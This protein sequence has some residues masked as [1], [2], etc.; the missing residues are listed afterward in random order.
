MNATRQTVSSPTLV[1]DR[2]ATSVVVDAL[3]SGGTYYLRYDVLRSTGTGSFL[4]G[5]SSVIQVTI[6]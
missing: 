3:P 4:V 2:L 6:P 1:T 5:R